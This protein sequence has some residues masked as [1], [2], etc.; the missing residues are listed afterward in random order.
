MLFVRNVQTGIIL[1]SLFITNSI[2]VGNCLMKTLNRSALVLIAV[3]FPLLASATHESESEISDRTAPV[4]EVY[5]EGDE[6]PTASVATATADSTTTAT[7]R[8]GEA[9]YNVSCTTCHAT[10]AANAPK[11]GDIAAWEPRIAKGM[12]ALIASSING[13]GAMPAKGMCFD[14]S[15]DEL[16]AT[17]EYMVENSQ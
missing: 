9:I 13:T 16:K 6:L 5:R 15:D 10:G 17:V 1:L 4:G 14:C 8:T 11:L 7:V 2:G 12:D 3:C